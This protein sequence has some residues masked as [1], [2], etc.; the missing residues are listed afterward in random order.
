MTDSSPAR[1][2][3][4]EGLALLQK[5]DHLPEA[6]A[7]FR[8]GLAT[9]PDHA[10]C[11]LHLGVTLRNL[12][13]LKEAGT[14]LL[15][16]RELTPEDPVVH[17]QIGTLL[18]AQKKMDEALDAYD[19]A[20]AIDPA[21]VNTRV[22]RAITLQA[23]NRWSEALRS[24]DR[25]ITDLPEDL[26]AA[27]VL[28]RRRAE[29]SGHLARIADCGV[30]ASLPPQKL[31]VA[32]YRRANGLVLEGAIDEAVRLYEDSAL[33]TPD[34][35]DPEFPIG[36]TVAAQMARRPSGEYLSCRWIEESLH[37]QQYRLAFCCVSHTR[38][39]DS[40]VAGAFHGGP[41]PIDFVLAR[42]HQLIQENQTGADNSCGGCPELER[43]SWPAS[44]WIFR[45]LVIGNHTVCNQKCGYC[46]LAI[47]NFEMSAY[48]YMAEP[49]IDSL[50]ANGWLPPD[51][52]VVWGGGEPT[53][54]RE[55][56]RIMAK[57]SA[58]SYRFNILSNVT[59]VMPVLVDALRQGRCDLVTSVD[60]GTPE[61]FY[62]IKYMSDGPVMV[63]GRPAF[64]IVWDNISKYTEASSE[65]VIVKYVFTLQN[66]ADADIA[67][68]IEQCLAHR[69]TRILLSPEI[70]DVLS[71]AVP[72]PVWE[73]INKA[74]ARA[75]AEGLT[76]YF[77]PLFLKAR[78]MPADMMDSLLITDRSAHSLAIR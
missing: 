6:E 4:S 54:S 72:A 38:G 47:A 15:R 25:L 42:R 68:F 50:M 16:A 22:A 17:M 19:T 29:V 5:R 51:A 55:F 52:Y 18:R 63:Q 7:A 13:R 14:V 41:V 67:G 66:I 76:V 43:R 69:V 8:A 31:A 35:S 2:A 46:A 1:K 53:L 61:T 12:G 75:H 39:K 32:L 9:D 26:I 34:Y 78:D 24:Y 58:T 27:N 44:P 21:H 74:K 10:G 60:S 20:L 56:S 57:L 64:D 3:Y 40:A 36:E 77:S 37:F 62:R 71:G 33:L 59:R 70:C 45:T 28:P 48:S 11:L 73:A 23:M 65:T 30:E 49:A